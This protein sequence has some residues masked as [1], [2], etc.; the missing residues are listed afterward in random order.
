MSFMS[1]SCCLSLSH[2]M[3]C[4]S[5]AHHP[6]PPFPPFG[7]SKDC[8]PARSAAKPVSGTGLLR[9]PC[10]SHG[11]FL[12]IL[13]SLAQSW[14]PWP[15][16]QNQIPTPAS[17]SL[18]PTRY[19][20]VYWSP[21]LQCK[22]HEDYSVSSMSQPDLFILYVMG[23]GSPPTLYAFKKIRLSV[24]SYRYILILISMC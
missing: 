10:S 1:L 7:S 22:L 6:L 13:L 20:C 9:F 23:K 8:L 15:S 12:L 17:Y 24:V 4:C 11:C 21:W 3:S 18:S 19:H 2:L 16:Q 5:T 14:F